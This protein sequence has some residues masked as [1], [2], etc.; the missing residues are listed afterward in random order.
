MGDILYVVASYTQKNTV[1]TCSL[2]AFRPLLKEAC[3]SKIIVPV[4]PYSVTLLN[5]F[6]I[7][8]IMESEFCI[9]LL[10]SSFLEFEFCKA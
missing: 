5:V 6:L 9:C 7:L 2:T 10:F 3:L 1:F 8:F 4:I